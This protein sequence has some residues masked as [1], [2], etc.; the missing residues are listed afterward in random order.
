MRL[1]LR[2]QKSTRAPAAPAKAR[3]RSPK[4]AALAFLAHP[5]SLARSTISGDETDKKMLQGGLSI[6]CS[7]SI[8]CAV[9]SNAHRRP[10]DAG[11]ANHKNP[12]Q[13][14]NRHACRDWQ[15]SGPQ[16]AESQILGD[17]MRAAQHCRHN[18][19]RDDV[20]TECR[21]N[22]PIAWQNNCFGLLTKTVTN[23]LTSVTAANWLARNGS[24]GPRADQYRAQIWGEVRPI[25]EAFTA[26]TPAAWRQCL[27]T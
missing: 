24:E 5:G 25:A 13:R 22:N 26:I 9:R 27:P 23:Q 14:R 21:P 4:L 6:F 19:Q 18:D 3:L 2:F 7:I 16:S 11:L 20:P 15:D 17:M 10:A 1:R 12:W 8:P